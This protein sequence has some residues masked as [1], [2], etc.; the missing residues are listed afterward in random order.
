MLGLLLKKQMTEIFR[1]YFYSSKNNKKRSVGSTIGFFIL[2]LFLMVGVVGGMFVYLSITLCK[3]MYAAKMSWLYF[4]IMAL[5]AIVLGTLGS[6]FN[7]FQQLYISK[8]NDLLLSMPM[9][10]RSIVL[11]RLA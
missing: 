11:A 4:V 3:P 2:Y 10:I 8:D 6:V 9:P 5:L 1:G 7:T